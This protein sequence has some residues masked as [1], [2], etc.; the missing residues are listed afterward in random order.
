[1]YV[2]AGF[3]CGLLLLLGVNYC[4]DRQSEQHGAAKQAVADQQAVVAK[5]D[6]IVIRDTIRLRV[7]GKRLRD[8][9]QVWRDRVDTLHD[10]VKIATAGEVKGIIGTCSLYESECETTKN[11]LLKLR[12]DYQKLE[13]TYQ[14]LLKSPKPRRR[15]GL[16]CSGGYSTVVSRRD[17]EVHDGPGASCGVAISF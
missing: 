2:A 10:T 4:R 1:M 17:H 5:T 6:S 3:L 15:W 13:T 9:I 8:T 16:G 14:D 12:T 11:N 7:A